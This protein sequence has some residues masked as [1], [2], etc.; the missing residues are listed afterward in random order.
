VSGNFSG[1]NWLGTNML[2]DTA[3]SSA[4]LARFDTSGNFLWVRT[5]T[6]SNFN[7]ISYHRLVS[8]SA[9]NVTLSALV[10][11]TAA[12][13]N[14]NVTV[15]G[16]QGLLVQFDANGNVRWLEEPSAWPVYLSSQNG[17]IYGAMGGHT[18][19]YVGG[20]TNISD[21]HYALFSLNAT[22][23]QGLWVQGFAA[24]TNVG[25]PYGLIDDN[26][27]LTVSGTNLF[28]AGTAWTNATFGPF[29]V[30]FPGPK[31]QY[32]AR[33][34]T[35]GNAQIATAF[36][37]Q[38]TAPWSIAADAN[39]NVYVGGDFD[40]YSIFGNDI[41]A[42]PFND[43][44]Q[45]VGPI[46]DRIPGQA[47]VAKLDRNGNPLWAKLAE[48]QASHVNSRDIAVASDGVWL[49]GFFNQFATFDSFTLNGGITVVGFP[50]GTI[51]YHPGAYLAKVA[52]STALPVTLLNSQEGGGNFQ[53][54]FVS[55]TGFN[56]GVQYGTNLMTGSNWQTYT[57]IPGDGTLKTV[58]IPLF[59]FNP[60]QQGYI[61]VL[62]Q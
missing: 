38:Y 55:Q 41:I 2:V 52:F 40:T 33:Y 29:S 26:P 60:S 11:G 25:N 22:N 57:N 43:T 13:G 34:D 16:Q 47:F 9:G 36:G 7:F 44:V 32:F 61:R 48:S 1:T 10:S 24:Q 51:T 6:G 15:T 8:D 31:G 56:H 23:G 46:D 62:T 20:V 5:I 17:R 45:Y 35:N 42:A 39:G 53:V 49:C 58:S 54:S 3:G 19:N 14:T 21:R 50:F 59:L 28:V 4:F 30:N 37:S 18:V 27:V 12:I